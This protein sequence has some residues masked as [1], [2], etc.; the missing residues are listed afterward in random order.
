[1]NRKL[2]IK[3]KRRGRNPRSRLDFATLRRPPRIE[4]KQINVSANSATFYDAAAGSIV[5]DITAIAQG[6]T[7]ATRVGDLAMLHSLS[8]KFLIYNGIGATCNSVVVSRVLFFQYMGDSS[9]ANKPTIAEMFNVSNANGGTTYGS[10]SAFDI[11]YARQYHVLYDTT[12]MTIGAPAGATS[13]YAGITHYGQFQVP[14]ARAQ[15]EISFYAGAT[16]GPNHIYMAVT[17][18][19]A[20]VATNPSISYNLDVRF[21]DT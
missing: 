15:R 9:V 3:I 18:N 11:D 17:S 19:C 21:T 12:C 8:Y 13:T 20:S 16:T 7:G 2:K 4:I 10:F 5:L 14:L 6:N 1:M